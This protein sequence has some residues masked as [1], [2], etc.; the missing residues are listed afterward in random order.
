MTKQKQLLG[1]KLNLFY[2]ALAVAWSVAF[3]VLAAVTYYSDSEIWLLTVSQKLLTPND[4]QIIYFKWLFHAITYLFSHWAPSEV[5]VYIWA[6]L[7]WSAIGIAAVALMSGVLCQVYDQKKWWAPAFTILITCSLF[8][9]QGFRVRGDVLSLLMHALYLFVFLKAFSAEPQRRHLLYLTLINFCLIL[10]TPKFIIFLICQFVVCWMWLKGTQK[11]S[12]RWFL[13]LVFSHFFPLTLGSGIVIALSSLGFVG[14]L[15]AISIAGDF[16]LKSY[17]SHLSNPLQFSTMDF[18]HVFKLPLQSPVHFALLLL[19]LGLFVYYTIHSQK[20]PQK[21]RALQVYASLLFL[22]VIT[23]NQKLP[24]FLGPFLLPVLAQSVFLV[25]WLLDS[26]QLKKANLILFALVI[27]STLNGAYS[28]VRNFYFNSNSYQITALQ[29]IEAYQKQNPQ[30]NIY[31]VIGLLPRKTKNYIFIGPSEVSHKAHIIELIL[32]ADPDLILSTY[33]LKYLEPEFSRELSK[34]WIPLEN[35]VWAKG[36]FLSI[37]QT[38]DQFLRNHVI[39]HQDYWL[40]PYRSAKYMYDATTLEPITERVFVLDQDLKVTSS[41]PKFFAVPK[42]HVSLICSDFAPIGLDH[43]PTSLF[44][45]DTA[46]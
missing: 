8:L 30:I 41:Q 39:D 14:P 10:T 9:N 4:L 5:Q 21:I 25:F 12:R 16:Y 19:W 18:F 40:L 13:P 22:L 35:G 11:T 24:F 33:K 36:E 27:S 29:K 15:T 20:L 38:P 26:L 43:S 23:Y 17:N 7:G 34:K 6:R 2:T 45:F 46:F 42:N 1:T 3:C 44:R 31:D 28:F 32:K 37:K